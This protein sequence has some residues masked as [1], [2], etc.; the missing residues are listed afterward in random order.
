MQKFKVKNDFYMIVKG[1][2]IKKI[3]GESI[4]VPAGKVDEFKKMNIIGAPVKETKI[5][6][7]TIQPEENEV[8]KY[9]RKRTKRT[10]KVKYES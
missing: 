6:T 5:E 7:A 9:K 8:V 10:K 3:K 1:K 4:N 2:R